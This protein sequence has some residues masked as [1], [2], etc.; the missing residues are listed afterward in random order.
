M[1]VEKPINKINTVSPP[2]IGS[3]ISFLLN[4]NTISI[5]LLLYFYRAVVSFDIKITFSCTDSSCEF[6][7]VYFSY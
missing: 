7:F 4:L 6:F 3:N 1:G 2:I 5:L